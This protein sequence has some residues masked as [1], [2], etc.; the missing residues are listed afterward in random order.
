MDEQLRQPLTLEAAKAALRRQWIGG[1]P[2]LDQLVSRLLD[3]SET[4]LTELVLEDALESLRAGHSVAADL[5]I[6]RFPQLEKL[7]AEL[8]AKIESLKQL[9]SEHSLAQKLQDSA[10]LDFFSQRSLD[11]AQMF[12]SNQL[13]GQEKPPPGQPPGMLENDFPKEIGNFRIIRLIGRGSFGSVFEGIDK[14]LDRKV[15]IKVKDGSSDRGLSDDFL[16]EAKSISKLEHPN[17][18][19]LLQADETPEGVGYLVYEFVDGDMLDDRIKRSDYTLEECVEWIASIADALDYAHRRGIV[20]RDI[21]PR[22]I[23]ITKDGTARLLDF[24][25]SSIDGTFYIEDSNRVLGT[26]SFMSPEQASGNPHWA[27]SHSDIFS[28]GSVLYYALTQKLAFAGT[29]VFDTLERIQKASPAPPRSISDNIPVKLEEACLRALAKEPQM[30]FSTGADMSAALINSLSVPAAKSGDKSAAF[31]YI[32]LALGV[33]VAV[34]GIVS[35]IVVLMEPTPKQITEMPDITDFDILVDQGTQRSLIYSDHIDKDD[36]I[37]QGV[38][39]LGKVFRM[40]VSAEIPKN[41]HARLYHC[42]YDINSSQSPTEL[43]KSGTWTCHDFLMGS[44]SVEGGELKLGP[45]ILLL[46]CSSQK[47]LL[48]NPEEL[49]QPWTFD[50]AS[51]TVK[52]NSTSKDND[53]VDRNFIGRS[54]KFKLSKQLWI[55]SIQQDASSSAIPLLRETRRAWNGPSSS[56]SVEIENYF[57]RNDVEYCSVAFFVTE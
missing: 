30:R 56:K 34:V 46:V 28:L 10:S 54:S 12:D 9:H 8:E 48:P 24:G 55:H 23:M 7:R 2:N 22:N 52:K 57:Q 20:H 47:S 11:Q 16:H 37:S 21:S 27:T 53:S 6:R 44:D 33:L 5:Y 40:R 4:S 17:I 35:T 41:Y 38:V 42:R 19:R 29:S 45:N 49:P 14:R 36:E 39:S 1:N 15:A 26:P 18:V 13:S 25:L 43:I 31:A 51:A 32:A 3:S 50:K